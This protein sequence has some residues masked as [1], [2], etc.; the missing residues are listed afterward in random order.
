MKTIFNKTIAL[1]LTFLFVST[2]FPYWGF[3][4]SRS[5]PLPGSVKGYDRSVFDHHFSKA[6]RELSPERWLSEARRGIGLAINAWEIFSIDLFDSSFEKDDAKR[7]LEKWSEEEL[8]FRF[9]QWLIN[10]FFGAEIENITGQLSA[11]VNDIHL[12]YTYHIDE[13]G[14]LLREEKTGD[15]RIIRPGDEGSDFAADLAKWYE[16]SQKNIN[17]LS[18]YFE[19]SVWA[20]FPELLAYFTEDLHDSMLSLIGNAAGIVSSALQTEFE[21]II[22]R[23][24]RLFTGR[25]TGDIYSLRKKSEMEEAGYIVSSLID[26]A[27]AVCNAGIAALQSRIEAAA[28]GDGDLALMGAE[29]LE[30]YRE[31]FECGLKIW[32]EAE[33]RFFI[34]R[35]EWEQNSLN[36]FEQGEETWILA[37]NRLEEERNNWE[38]QVKKLIE[39]GEEI[40]KKASKDIEAA[41]TLARIE[42][43]SNLELRTQSGASKAAVLVDM[44]FTC[45]SAAYTA[46]ENGNFFINYFNI[47]NTITI[48]DDNIY[49]WIEN[50]KGTKG[51]NYDAIEL[52]DEIEKAADMYRTFYTKALEIRDNILNDFSN[53][54]GD[55]V[56]KDILGE[57]ISTEDFVLD[58]YQIALIKAKV[59]VNYWEK[60]TDIA[61]AVQ[62]YA[63]DIGA[64]RMTEAES[65]LQWENA[66]AAYE[67]SVAEYESE[68]NKLNEIGAE[69]NDKT[70]ILNNCLIKINEAGEELK[71]INNEYYIFVQTN[72]PNGIEKIENDLLSKYK[73]LLAQ[74]KLIFENDGN[75]IFQKELELAA[76][77]ELIANNNKKQAL[78]E[79]LINGDGDEGFFPSYNDLKNAWEQIIL[80]DEFDPIPGSAAECGINANDPRSILIDLLIQEGDDNYNMIIRELCYA[81][82]KEAYV[83]LKTREMEIN[84]LVANDADSEYGSAEWYSDAWAVVYSGV[85]LGEC[86]L[87][88]YEETFEKLIE[89]RVLIEKDALILFVNEI[90]SNDNYSNLLTNFCLV[91]KVDAE[92]GIIA[93]NILSERITNGENYVNGND[94][95]ENIIAWFISGGSFF[96][97]S[98]IFITEELY[99]YNLAEGLY[100][101][102]GILSKYSEFIEREKWSEFPDTIK[103]FFGNYGIVTEGILPKIEDTCFAVYNYS[104]NNQQ[105]PDYVSDVAIFLKGLDKIFLNMP[106]WLKEE[107]DGWKDSFVNY[108]AVLFYSKIS[109]MNLTDEIFDEEY[110]SLQDRY[111]ALDEMLMINISDD[112]KTLKYFSDLYSEISNDK[113]LIDYKLIV[114]LTIETTREYFERSTEKEWWMYLNEHDFPDIDIITESVEGRLI[115]PKAMA[116]IADFR[117][118]YVLKAVM[119]GFQD[120]ENENIE[121]LREYYKAEVEASRKHIEKLQQLKI[122][123]AMAGQNYRY[124]TIPRGTLEEELIKFQSAIENLNIIYQARMD[125]YLNASSDLAETAELYDLQY[126]R[127]KT[128]YSNIE[129][130]RN[131][132]EKQDAIRRWASTAYLGTDIND[133]AYCREKLEKAKIVFDVLSD[134]YSDDDE[135]R[136]Y[137]NADYER[138]YSEYKKSIQDKII[139]DK[140]L[141]SLNAD[142]VHRINYSDSVYNLFINAVNDL[143]KPFLYPDDYTSPQNKG[144]WT[145]QD[146][147]TLKDGK[148][149]LNR[150]EQFVITGINSAKVEEINVYFDLANIK[151]GQYHETTAFQEEV[152]NLGIRMVGYFQNEYKMTQ[153]GLARDYLIRQLVASNNDITFLRNIKNKSD[154]LLPNGLLGILEFQGLGGLQSK[155][156]KLSDMIQSE[157]SLF[158][159]N[160]EN[161]WKGL[162]S[163]EK[164]DLEFY[165]I[166]TLTNGNTYNIG[167]ESFTAVAQLQFVYDEVKRLYDIADS[168]SQWYKLGYYKQMYDVNQLAKDRVNQTLIGEKDILLKW[169]NG[170]KANVSYINLYYAEYI[171]SCES[172]N[173][174]QNGLFGENGVSWLDIKET[175]KGFDTLSEEE[176]TMLETL[177]VKMEQVEDIKYTGIID[178]IVGFVKWIS[179]KRDGDREALESQWNNDDV[180][181]RKKE[182]MYYET[183]E[184]FLDGKADEDDL[185]TAMEDAF[186]NEA[187]AWKNHFNNMGQAIL[188]TLGE[189]HIYGPDYINGFILLEE[190]YSALVG[191]TFGMGFL[192]EIAVRENEWNQQ[193]IDIAEKFKTWSETAKLILTRGREDW[194]NGIQKMQESYQRWTE[195]FIAEY[196]NVSILW[197]EAYL[198]GLE[199]K[200]KW[201]E[202]V[203]ETADNASTGAMISAIG[204]DAEMF[205]RK[206]DTRDVIGISVPNASFE[207]EN[208]LAN[209]LNSTGITSMVD[210]FSSV[211]NLGNLSNYTIRS[212]INRTGIWD[213]TNARIE[214]AVL[215]QEANKSIKDRESKRL[216]ASAKEAAKIALEMLTDNVKSANEGFNS[217]MDNL[218]RI[219]GQWKKDNGK[220][221]KD[222]V[223]GSTLFEHVLYDRREVKGYV[224][225]NIGPISLTTR[226][227]DEYLEGLE[228]FAIQALIYKVHDEV[229]VIASGIFGNG[230]IIKVDEERSYGSGKFGEYI[231]YE[232]LVRDETAETKEVMFSDKGKGELGRLLTEYSYFSIIDSRGLAEISLPPWDK[233]IWDDRGKEFKSPSIRSMTDLA[234]QVGITVFSV[235]SAIAT[236]GVGAVGAM[237]LVAAIN[238]AD[239]LMFAT[240]D[241][242]FGYKDWKEAGFEFGKTLLL[243]ATTTALSAVF[244]GVP[245]VEKGFFKGGLN[246]LVEEA[247]D[248]TVNK[249][250]AQT[251][252]TGV[253]AFTTNTVTSAISGI[254]Y[255]N[256]SLGY[257]SDIFK[258]GMSATWKNALT[259]M[260]STLVSGTFQGINSGMNMEKLTGF[261]DATNKKWVQVLNNTIGA[262]AGQGINFAMGGDFSLNVFNTAIFELMGIKNG[263]GNSGLLELH[264]GRDGVKMNFG[265]GGADV[266]LSSIIYSVMGA[267]VWNVN[268]QIEKYT[269]KNDFDAKVT[270]RAQ[271]GFGEKAEK[272]QLWEILKGKAGVVIGGGD[273]FKAKTDIIDGIRTIII[274]GYKSGMSA[275]EQMLLAVILGHE[276]YRDGIVTSDNYMETRTA[277]L[278]HTEMALRMLLDGQQLALDGNLFKDILA[279][280]ISNGDMAMFYSYV[281]NNYDS[282]ND[283]WKL[284]YD[285][286]LINDNNGWLTMVDGKPVLNTDGQQIGANGIETGL[287]NIIFGGTSGIRYSEYNEEQIRFAQNLMINAGMN[288]T[289]GEGGTIQSRTWGGNVIGQQLDMGQIMR[290]AGNTVASPVFTRYYEKDAMTYMTRWDNVSIPLNSFSRFYN[291]LLPAIFV[292]NASQRHFLDNPEEYRITG[293]HDER[294]PN[295]KYA[296]YE[297]D[298]HFGTDFANGKSGGSIFAGIPGMVR[299]IGQDAGDGTG[300]GNWIVIE[301][302]YMFEGNFIGSGVYGEY[303]HMENKPDF[304]LNTYLDSNQILGTLGNTGRSSGAHLHYSIYT[305][306]NNTSQYNAFSGTTLWTL[307]NGNITQTVK[308]RAAKYFVGTYGNSA[309]KVTY[310]IEYYLNYL[311]RR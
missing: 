12:R 139:A 53:I 224:D 311:N 209:L 52:L 62:E 3:A 95:Y 277:V 86:L 167:F 265:T 196:E 163:Q 211:N 132:Y 261:E 70:D 269:Q 299:Y 236:A 67:K 89:K 57:N 41:I 11:S 205:S 260:T 257:N 9:T 213:G 159:S 54:F 21:N 77:I 136:P 151:E 249:V 104:A 256:G 234:L 129:N 207:A 47:N 282:S 300:S 250:L 72:S 27:T 276:A 306:Q 289:E 90:T 264:I 270:L 98:E 92:D 197:N 182:N 227:D 215:A 183:I 32:E 201:L 192:A 267:M 105:R 303:M 133:T 238:S 258:Q 147:I 155:N 36:L 219:Q 81:A 146:I 288:Y 23:E 49:E 172:I 239:E 298:A 39:S 198:A 212:G 103:Q 235:A 88:D 101:A 254:T 287:L 281:D 78:I 29:W 31:Q 164:A 307:L 5:E 268:N 149:S 186:G 200:E 296:N 111:D 248:G 80:L 229:G 48:T 118:N 153:W 116:S 174:L 280:S 223:V 97:I 30:M 34:R 87:V 204:R 117:T 51:L 218:F 66:K 245:G 2:M 110:T 158:Y 55:G 64:G 189:Y 180:E 310:D 143:G 84:M 73:E 61:N 120:V 162:S 154:A 181:R 304:V 134:L 14:N 214:A 226:L 127:T 294:D 279:Y 58:E 253:Q 122:E 24:Q 38:L 170:I 35:V 195:N 124:A 135:I 85:D 96:S 125:E 25:R 309:T 22:A 242:A 278:A 144:Q 220:Y 1:F 7:K 42:I 160:Q 184:A 79:Y 126:S 50:E 191:T 292:N 161:A 128:A 108:F 185:R 237:A 100:N 178:G 6:D 202:R 20:V 293:E 82:K 37:F 176:L 230:E 106:S 266:S 169:K 283:Y 187:S 142:L 156:P 262:V 115:D 43:L 28:G 252:M 222:I 175:I 140:L 190:E 15:P 302:G 177:W 46:I 59:L 243:S 121:Q 244:G 112:I 56:L 295:F 138:L 131:E 19:T 273:D 16:E 168:N 71:R 150:N 308:S 210:A 179:Q 13:D 33:E 255:T 148:L 119:D 166:L 199:D 145:I 40:F 157:Q 263:G 206:M 275:E 141:N 290:S 188:D 68:M 94:L 216:A 173:V 193:M 272:D 232:P 99:D 194:N 123:F 284:T 221:I 109:T 259:S 228:S 60:R 305:L 217:S 75:N 74:Y 8:E 171:N 225:Y 152:K 130:T 102:Y 107:V 271:Y 63:T 297:N 65:I 69:I 113:S 26:Q 241:T 18:G 274:N 114:F 203:A 44:Y 233:R 291:E 4:Q 240:L 91:N 246:G 285:G 231:G 301:Y 286:R 17:V 247:A 208:I 165:I 83:A 10:R 45:V 251:V 137:Q 76:K 93:L